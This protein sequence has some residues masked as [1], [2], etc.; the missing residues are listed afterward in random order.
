MVL[1]LRM[2]NA[3]DKRSWKFGLNLIYDDGKR[4]ERNECAL[5]TRAS[6]AESGR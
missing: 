2:V 3:G 1:K 6:T 5:D 4:L